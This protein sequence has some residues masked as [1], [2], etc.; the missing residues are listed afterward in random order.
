MK[1][2]TH[3]R[4]S[5][6]RRQRDALAAARRQRADLRDVAVGR[7]RG[8]QRGLRDDVDR[9]VGAT[10]RSVM[11]SSC[12]LRRV[13]V[14]DRDERS[15]SRGRSCTARCRCARR[16]GSCST[17]CRCRCRR[18]SHRGRRCRSRPRSRRCGFPGHRRPARRSAGSLGCSRPDGS[19]RT[20]RAC[21]K[22]RSAR[23]R[24]RGSNAA[25]RIC[26]CSMTCALW[27]PVAGDAL[28]ARVSTSNT[29][30]NAASRGA[31]NL[32]APMF[33]GSSWTQ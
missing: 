19:E 6:R 18:R 12:D 26:S 2:P 5:E 15:S 33:A 31:T 14:A 29:G 3:R 32:A 30:R 4:P 24:Q 13:E 1:S 20:G 16:P 17:R 28:S 8:V 25:L 22:F 9:A 7:A 27:D 21:V 10:A 23:P 11:T